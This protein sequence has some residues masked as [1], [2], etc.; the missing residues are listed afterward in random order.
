MLK[1]RLARVGKRNHATFRIVATEH[2]RPPKSGALAYLGSYDPH[3][4]RVQVDAERLNG[5]LAHGA[6]VSATLHNLFIEHKVLEGTKV[7]S[8][9]PKKKA[10]AV[11]TGAPAATPAPTSEVDSPRAE[12]RDGKTSEVGSAPLAEPTPPEQQPPVT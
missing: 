8:W 1:I 3:T 11:T 9:K 12:S 5:Y 2:S 10:A 4:N 7:V 6:Q